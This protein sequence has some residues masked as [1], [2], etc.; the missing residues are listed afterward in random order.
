MTQN[1]VVV[2]SRN[3]ENIDFRFFASF[4]ADLGMCARY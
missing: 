1:M 2:M 3:R 4:N